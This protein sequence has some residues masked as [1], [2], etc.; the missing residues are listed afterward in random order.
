MKEIENKEFRNLYLLY[1]TETYIIDEAVKKITTGVLSEE[2][3][4]FN[5]SQYDLVDTPIE[6]AIDDAETM[7]FMGDKKVV[8]VK[9]AFFLT[10]QK[11]KGVEHNVELFEQYVQFPCPTTVFIVIAPYESLDKRKK[12][13][14]ALLKHAGVIEATSFNERNAE[15]WIREKAKEMN[16]NITPDAIGRLLQNVGANLQMLENELLKME[17]Y[18]GE[19]G[20]ITEET[21]DEMVA[22]TLEQNVFTLVD[23]VVN[24]KIDDALKIFYDLLRQNEEP[25][26]IASLITRQFRIIFQVK[27][28]SGVPQAELAKRLGLHPYAVKVALQQG[29][30]FQEDELIDILNKLAEADYKMKT[31][32]NKQLELEMFLTNL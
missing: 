23:K 19:G 15:N 28:L 4:E 10:G 32:N 30:Q 5:L 7:S 22:K 6:V 14:K 2:D 20:T 8:I 3:M 16:V 18:V 31:G 26:K 27:I 25:I 11:E 1:G 12:I 9:N 21:I 13:T 24:R 17:M 29:S